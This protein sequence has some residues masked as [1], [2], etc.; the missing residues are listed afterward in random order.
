LG[1]RCDVFSN[2]IDTDSIPNIVSPAKVEY[3]I[4]QS[5]AQLPSVLVEMFAICSVIIFT[6]IFFGDY[7][8]YVTAVEP[9]NIS[10]VELVQ[11]VLMYIFLL[12]RCKHR[13]TEVLLFCFV[14]IDRDHLLVRQG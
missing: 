9:K 14:I 2:E 3:L 4:R 7:T 12:L 13:K 10:D 8:Q 5:L 6:V 1:V 11:N